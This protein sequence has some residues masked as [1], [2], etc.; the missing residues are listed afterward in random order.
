[1]RRIGLILLIVFGSL[2]INAA[3]RF[4]ESPRSMWFY[5]VA[6]NDFTKICP[7]TNHLFQRMTSFALISYRNQAEETD[8]V[9]DS[10]KLKTDNGLRFYIVSG[11]RLD[12]K[13]QILLERY[14]DDFFWD[15]WIVK[16]CTRNIANSPRDT[17]EFVGIKLKLDSV[18]GEYFD[19]LVIL[20]V[21]LGNITLAI[22]FAFRMRD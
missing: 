10:F 3:Y 19:F 16:G 21:L 15:H 11:T 9:V 12:D 17:G 18:F 13:T 5:A 4:L 14:F 1:M 22:L 20:F 8:V 7:R 2:L 6:Y